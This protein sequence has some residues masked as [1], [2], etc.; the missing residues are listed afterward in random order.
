MEIEYNDYETVDRR[1][2]AQSSYK[3]D[4]DI[5]IYS[6]C[7]H[8]NK[9]FLTSSS[10]VFES[11]SRKFIFPD[12]LNNIQNISTNSNNNIILEIGGQPIDVFRHKFDRLDIP[13]ILLMY[14]QVWLTSE[15]SHEIYTIT[16]DYNKQYTQQECARCEEI[17][18]VKHFR[19]MSGMIGAH[20]F[21]KYELI[22]SDKNNPGNKSATVTLIDGVINTFTR[23]NQREKEKK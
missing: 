8:G 3:Y 2:I 17:I 5:Y 22:C 4:N 13:T 14:H 16:T 7:I 1:K 11:N 23:N 20:K 10:V 21:D 15:D 6:G 18:Y 12:F 19:V 9:L